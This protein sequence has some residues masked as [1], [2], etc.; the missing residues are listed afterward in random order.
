MNT[1]IDILIDILLHVLSYIIYIGGL[2][3][4][5]VWFFNMIRWSIHVSKH[6]FD[7]FRG[8]WK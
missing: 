3:G 8:W 7:P 5:L 4:L 1:L 6:D 2:I